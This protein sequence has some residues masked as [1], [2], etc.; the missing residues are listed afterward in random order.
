MSKVVFTDTLGKIDNK[1]FPV[2]AIKYLPEWYAKTPGYLSDNKS[3]DSSTIKKCM[4]VLDSMSAGYLILTPCDFY[5]QSIGD[6]G[7]MIHSGQRPDLGIFDSHSVNQA[8]LHPNKS[9]PFFHKWM[10]PWSIKTE[11]GYSC[12]ITQ[13][14]HTE[15]PITI[16]SGIIDTDKY[17]SPINFVFTIKPGFEGTIPAG[18]PI[19]QVLPFRR[20]EYIMSIG[21]NLL[22]IKENQEKLL[23]KLYNRY[24]DVFWSRKEYK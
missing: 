15:S 2:P 22:E 11:D 13:P 4:P 16:L 21:N 17:Y 18:T 14:M 7:N 24:R 8:E 5:T 12:L 10:N 6:K 23:S 3:V 19:A 9:G 1:F 20:E